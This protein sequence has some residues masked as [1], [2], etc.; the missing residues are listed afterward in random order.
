MIEISL[1]ELRTAAGIGVAGNIAGH[2]EQ[3]GEADDFRNVVLTAAEAPKGIFP[4]YLPGRAD[5]LGEFPLSSGALTIPPEDV[6]VDLQIEPEVGVIARLTYDGDGQVAMIAPIAIA[7]F[8]DCSIRRRGAAKISHKKNWGS[9]SKGLA[10]HG[11][12]V[13]AIDPAGALATMRIVSFLRRGGV[14]YECGVDSPA[15]A[16]SYAGDTLVDWIVGRL[17][18]QHGSDDTPLEPVGAYL[19]ECGCP[20]RAVV[21]I[22]ATRYTPV[23]ESTYL[24]EGDESIV[25]VYDETM[26]TPAAVAAAV[27][28]R[29][30]YALPRASVLRQVVRSPGYS[31]SDT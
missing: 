22:G 11:F 10:S 19:R 7:A 9:A 24:V 18:N 4:W 17:A 26:T 15:R 14:A 16:Y 21:G 12:A 5:F 25:V 28:A 27:E 29:D 13:G 3:A 6:A 23:G 30:K 8:N 31:V 20:E 1:D 2:L